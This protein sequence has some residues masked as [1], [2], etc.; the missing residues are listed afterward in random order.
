MNTGGLNIRRA[1]P[2]RK[3]DDDEFG[4]NLKGM[5][6]ALHTIGTG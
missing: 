6:Q 2:S 1:I 3:D 5:D 4:A